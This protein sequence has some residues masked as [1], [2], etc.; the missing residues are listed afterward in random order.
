[1]SAIATSRV[2]THVAAAAAAVAAREGVD[3]S[4]KIPIA[5]L[6]GIAAAALAAFGAQWWRARGQG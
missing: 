6:V 4:L 1:M 2:L 3:G 5:W